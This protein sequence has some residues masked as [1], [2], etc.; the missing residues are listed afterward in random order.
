MCGGN[1]TTYK[2]ALTT[3]NY[4]SGYGDNLSCTWNINVEQGMKIKINVTDF[5]TEPPAEGAS[6]STTDYIEVN[7]MTL[8]E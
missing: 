4:P 5:E 2:G 6:C 1:L 3:P 8:H 7:H